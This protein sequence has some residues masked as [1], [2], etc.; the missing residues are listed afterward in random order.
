MRTT[1]WNTDMTECTAVHGRLWWRRSARARLDADAGWGTANWLLVGGDVLA[2]TLAFERSPA[3]TGDR[4]VGDWLD[5]EA[6]GEAR[7]RRRSGGRSSSGRRLVGSGG[8][9]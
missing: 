1:G 9:R 8:A 4:V 7:R 5:D 6:M 2:I 3:A